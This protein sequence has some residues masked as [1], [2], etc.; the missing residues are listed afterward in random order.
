MSSKPSFS[1]NQH[2]LEL[3]KN[4]ISE[5]LNAK[6]EEVTANTPFLELGA[7]SLVLMEI[8]QF[9]ETH[10]SVSISI[11]RIFEDLNTPKAVADHIVDQL[12]ADWFKVTDSPKESTDTSGLDHHFGQTT[13]NPSWEG[14]TPKLPGSPSP[15]NDQGIPNETENLISQSS[16]QTSDSMQQ[17]VM[18]QLEIMSRQLDLLKGG[19]KQSMD[20]AL[21]SSK[22]NTI[23]PVLKRKEK[24]KTISHF[25]SFHDSEQSLLTPSQ[26]NYLDRFVHRYIQRTQASKKR[27]EQER[28]NWADVRSLMGMRPETKKLAYTLISEQ[29]QGSH[30]VDIDGNSYVDLA[31]GFGVHLFGHGAEFLTQ[32]LKIQI[33][34]GVHLG[35]QS[36]LS[37]QVAQ[38]IR[39]LT[40]VERVAFC[41]TG[42]EAVMSAIRLARAYTG[43]TKIAMF[44]GSYHGHSDAVLATSGQIDG[45]QCTLPLMPGVTPSSVSDTMVLNYGKSDALEGIRLNADTLAAVL[46]EPVPSRQPSMQPKEFLKQL[47]AL[48]TQLDIPLIFD[49]MITGFRI[50]QGGAQ[51]FFDIKADL[52]TYGK[53]IGGGMPIGVV[54]GKRKFI[55]QVDGGSWD[56]E[57][58]LSFPKVETTVAGAG[59]FRRHPLTMAASLAVLEHL[60]KEGNTLYDQLNQKTQ[61]L[62]E[63]LHAYFK[64]KN[65]PLKIARFGSLFRFVHSGNFSY[66]YQPLEMDLLHFG[67]IEKG[68]YLWEGRTCFIST[69]HTAEDM[70]QIVRA[71]QN[72]VE[73]LLKA[74]YFSYNKSNPDL[75]D[76]VTFLGTQSQAQNSSNQ[77]IS[78]SDNPDLGDKMTPLGTQSQAQNLSNQD[79]SLSDNPDLGDK[80]TPLGTQSQAQ[81]LSNQDISLSDNPDLGDKVTPLGAL[82]QTPLGRDKSLP[83][84]IPTILKE[85]KRPPLKDQKLPPL[86]VRQIPLTEA[87]TQLWTLNQISEGGA[88][89]TLIF[90]NLQLSGTLHQHIILES[91]K[92]VVTRH[93]ALRAF[94][95]P[96]GNTQTIQPQV[97]ISLPLIDLS[98]LDKTSKQHELN[99]LFQKEASI[100][101]ELNHP[102][103]FRIKI[104]R[105]KKDLH[106]LMVAASHL[107]IDGWSLMILL[108]EMFNLY[109]AQCQN[110]KLTMDD[111]IPFTDYLKWRKEYD[112]SQSMQNHEHFWLSKFS[113]N[114][115][116]LELPTDHTPPALSTYRASR[117]V[118]NLDQELYQK[119]RELS[120]R[121]K[122]TLF[123]VLLAAY[124]LFLHRISNQDELVVGIM[125]SGR[126]PEAHFR[127][128]GYCSH[129]V[130]IVSH[131]E[132]EPIFFEFLKGVKQELLDALEH[133]NYPFARLINQLNTQ[134]NKINAPLVTTTFNMDHPIELNKDLNLTSEWFPQPIH[135]LDNE[136]SVNVTDIHG[137]LVIEFDY[138]TELFKD[139]TMNRW[140]NHFQTLL[141]NIVNQKPSDSN[142][143]SVRVLSLMTEEQRYQLLET[144][145]QPWK[146]SPHH[147]E[148]KCL[149]HWFERWAKNTPNHKAIVLDDNTL[150]YEQLNVKANQLAHHLIAIGVGPESLVGVFLNRSFDMMVGILGILKSGGAYVALDIQQ[151]KPRISSIIEDANLHSLLA[152]QSLLPLLPK[153]TAQIVLMDDH[154]STICQQNTDNPVTKVHENNISYVVY[155]SGSTGTPKGVVVE[156]RAILRHCLDY[157]NLLHMTQSDNVSQFNALQF[158][159]S[160]EEIFSAI[161]SGATLILRGSEIW[162]PTEF[163][164][165]ANK[166]KITVAALTPAYF[167]QLVDHWIQIPEEAPKTVRAIQVGGDLFPNTL[168]Q[169]FRQTPLGSAQLVNGYGPTE[170]AIGPLFH[171]IKKESFPTDQKIPIGRP[172]GCRTAYILDTHKQLVPMGIP[173]EL[174]VGGEGQMARCYLNHPKWTEERFIADPFSTEE[175]AR[176]FKT[177]DLTRY[178]DNGEIE[179]LGRLDNQVKIRGF[180]VELGEIEKKLLMHEEIQD[181]VIHIHK[182][183]TGDSFLVAYCVSHQ[184][185][186]PDSHLLRSFLSQHLPDYMIPSHFVALDVLPLNINGKVDRL[187]LKIPDGMKTEMLGEIVEPQTPTEQSM[188]DIWS[189]LLDRSEI[190]IHHNFFDLGGHSLMAIQVISQLRD[191]LSVEIKVG[192]FFQYPT[193][194]TLSQQIDNTL[195]MQSDDPSEEEREEFIF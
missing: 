117:V 73:E 10:F 180:R 27:A 93:E 177:G 38:L 144:W 96:Q 166:H 111:P 116:V 83:R 137:Q 28:V 154:Y 60:K 72:T 175:K 86:D 171:L 102:P 114:I 44:S 119:L 1:T 85:Q 64:L 87:Q 155:T 43:R 140:I 191:H 34:K 157:G 98:H 48:T 103:L 6:L 184:K 123:M 143:P 132:G 20:P 42:T 59:T 134:K 135:S 52:V 192:L 49:E 138:S 68:V 164:H 108:R 189:K 25:S 183:N 150:T 74:G 31:Q 158:D 65:I 9:I 66:T 4:F 145:N 51:A 118:L 181:G 186:T 105:L 174:Y 187:A 41:C 126:A 162:T 88:L 190:S 100:P 55:D 106:R 67:L 195:K 35:P 161:T 99:Q 94:I 16:E 176:L 76:K 165:Q 129:I 160:V 47:R 193:I 26:K 115:P 71:V 146:L 90:T 131:L 133:Q 107:L 130:P 173:G 167:Q 79:I 75:G 84:P 136:L 185:P 188:A 15:N 156:H 39:E 61:R 182:T 32:A 151:P 101:I 40:G 18:R 78:L 62:E 148:E 128:I 53:I 194:H 14:G 153:T 37:G 142:Q 13:V 141:E 113:N 169:L 97:D 149:H 159:Y 36:N 70:D 46:V 120:G 45:K 29:A 170:T 95:D 139:T 178:L 152:H 30:F 22:D 81:N 121:C 172:L 2:V 33:D 77:D 57:D 69:A 110:T 168:L 7:D 54:A 58:E 82:P 147:G 50:E 91:L 127:M 56:S 5:Q 92:K 109:A 21:V 163:N 112:Q 63:R 89:T 122:T 80:M 8:L 23:Q 19:S 104:I 3:L 179:Y 17:V 11:R 12:P 124:Q 125:V 24:T